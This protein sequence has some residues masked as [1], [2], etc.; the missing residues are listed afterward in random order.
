VTFAARTLVGAGVLGLVLF[1]W[2]AGCGGATRQSPAT[3]TTTAP[4]KAAS[5]QPPLA[6]EPPGNGTRGWR[7]RG[8]GNELMPPWPPEAG[9]PDAPLIVKTPIE[10]ASGHALDAFYRALERIEPEQAQARIVVYGASHVASDLYTDII[11]SKLQTQFGDAGVGF[12]QPLR[13]VS[14]YRSAGVVFEE[15]TGWKGVHVKAKTPVHDRY[16]LGGIYVTAAQSRKGARLSFL[17]R[18]HAGSTGNADSIELWYLKQPGGGKL[19]VA[20]DGV[21][22]QL[23]TKA[24]E[25][26]AAYE[27]FAVKDAQ[28]RV[29]LSTAGNAPVQLFGVVMERK[30]PGVVVDSLGVP[31]SRARYHLLWD[32]AIYREHLARRK[33]NLVVLAY[34]TNE[35]GDDEEPIESYAEDLHKVLARIR[36]VTPAASCLLVGPSDRPIENPDGTFVDRPRTTQ[37]VEVQRKLSAE[38]GCG[39]FDMVAFMGGR[40][41][42]LRWVNSLPP[43]GTPD[44][45]HFTRAGYEALG[46]ALHS[47]LMA[48]FSPASSAPVPPTAA[49]T[50][51]PTSA[52][53]GAGK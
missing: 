12:V 16:G 40:L 22:R 17:T 20:I 52:S 31:G 44:Y 15:A 48:G 1:A 3:R 53:L 41:A 30:Q 2:H 27:R 49:K 5:S 21:D 45:V 13:A 25:P 14:G 10:D 32:D 8:A 9:D 46:I 26:K 28:H 35:S 42:M 4:P 18:P 51:R 36:E 11:R 47:A 39:F 29:E 7:R 19:R 38:F 50:S 43:L 34:G 23:N 33:P 24:R 6:A 37:I